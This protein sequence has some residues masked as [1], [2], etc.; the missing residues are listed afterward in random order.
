MTAGL[1]TIDRKIN[2]KLMAIASGY[3]NISIYHKFVVTFPDY[4]VSYLIVTYITQVH[5]S[6]IRDMRVRSFYYNCKF[7]RFSCLTLI[8]GKRPGLRFAIVPKLFLNIIKTIIT[9]NDKP[10]SKSKAKTESN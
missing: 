2:P 3:P 5:L 6:L 4:N 10:Q 9:I 8:I 1:N 7:K